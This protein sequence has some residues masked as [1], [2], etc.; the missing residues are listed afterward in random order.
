ML[1]VYVRIVE[2]QAGERV[3]ILQRH[4]VG[5]RADD[6]FSAREFFDGRIEVKRRLLGPRASRWQNKH[7]YERD[8]CN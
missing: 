1:H 5:L 6:G 7:G 2:I 8:D 3:A 4:I